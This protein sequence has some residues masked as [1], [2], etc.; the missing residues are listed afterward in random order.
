MATIRV[1]AE[2]FQELRGLSDEKLRETIVEE[3]NEYPVHGFTTIR[4]TDFRIYLDD[5]GINYHSN[6]VEVVIR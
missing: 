4:R 1:T 2:K 5:P 6:S 3:F